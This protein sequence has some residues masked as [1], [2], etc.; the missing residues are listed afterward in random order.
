MHPPLSVVEIVAVI[1]FLG[2][3]GAAVALHFQLVAKLREWGID[4][5]WALQNRWWVE[6]TYADVCRQKGIDSWLAIRRII[7][8]GFV[9]L[10]A[11]IVLMVCLVRS[12]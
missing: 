8:C 6:R 4:V 3:S 2:W 7:V 1:W 5:P 10:P 12:P 9:A 11:W